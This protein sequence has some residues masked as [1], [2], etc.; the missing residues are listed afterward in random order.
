MFKIVYLNKAKNVYLISWYFINLLT[1]FYKN[2]SWLPHLNVS[3]L[4]A[5]LKSQYHVVVQ[6]LYMQIKS[7]ISYLILQNIP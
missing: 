4:I 7:N 5:N 6:V 1:H 3:I 2:Y